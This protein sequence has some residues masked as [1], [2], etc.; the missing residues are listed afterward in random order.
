MQCVRTLWLWLSLCKLAPPIT[1]QLLQGGG[2]SST[3][4]DSV[5]HML[6]PPECRQLHVLLAAEAGK[7]PTVPAVPVSIM[8]PVALNPKKK[9]KFLLKEK[10][11]LSHNVRRYRFALPSASHKFGLP[12]GKHI[13][14]YAK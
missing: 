10:F 11:Q 6:Q 7:P 8:V 9:L 12:V 4:E 14:L 3:L 2:E 1:S 5:L 13:F